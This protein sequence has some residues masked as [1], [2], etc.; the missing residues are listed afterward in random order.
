MTL[1]MFGART[2]RWRCGRSSFRARYR[3]CSGQQPCR[4]SRLWT[5]PGSQR[6]RYVPSGNPWSAERDAALAVLITWPCLFFCSRQAKV[7]RALKL[8]SLYT[9]LEESIGTFESTKAVYN[10]MLELRVAT[11]EVGFL[12]Q[13]KKKCACG[14][15]DGPPVD[16]MPTLHLSSLDTDHHQF[17]HVPGGKQILRRVVYSVRAW[18]W[19]L[20]MARCV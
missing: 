7:H 19:P 3:S 16:T 1:L 10:R 11:P 4:A 14:E 15:C 8:W 5:R 2:R 12:A 18:H 6:C 17:C 13:H 9:D 20:Q